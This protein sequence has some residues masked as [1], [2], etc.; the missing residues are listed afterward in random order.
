VGKSKYFDFNYD[1]T[2]QYLL[3][4][5]EILYSVEG[6]RIT[7][8]T[9]YAAVASITNKRVIVASKKNFSKG[10][11]LVAIPFNKINLFEVEK[12]IKGMEYNFYVS[13]K[14]IKIEWINEDESLQFVKLLNQRL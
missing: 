10:Y 2:K 1:L 6:T 14:T 9:G 8:K 5:E 12:E 13:G 3:D 7:E 4:D 11:Y